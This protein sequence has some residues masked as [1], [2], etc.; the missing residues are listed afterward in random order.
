LVLCFTVSKELYSSNEDLKYGI[1]YIPTFGSKLVSNDHFFELQNI[2]PRYFGD[3]KHV[4]LLGYLN[5]RCK[6]ISDYTT[7]DDS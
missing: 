7:I 6:N 2:F 4:L 3:S 1:V 5:A